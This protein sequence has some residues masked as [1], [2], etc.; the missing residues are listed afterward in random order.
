MR[1]TTLPP[2]GFP[3]DGSVVRLDATAVK[4]LAHPLRSRLLSALRRQGPATATVLARGLGTNSGATSYHLRKLESVGLVR[5]SGE[6]AGKRRLWEAAS[7][8]T[9]WEGSQFVGDEDAETALNWLSRDYLRHLGARFERWL[10][11]EADWPAPWRDALG[12]ND[13]VA[14]L[15]AQQVRAM[16]DEISEVVLRYRRAGQG[17]PDARR[18]AVYTVTYPIDL[19]RAPRATGNGR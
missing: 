1:P 7:D 6:G 14:V 10:D 15:T 19:D 9:S 18:V 2:G 8:Y 12:M 16:T 3:D 17:N 11:V 13:D 5:D 4:V